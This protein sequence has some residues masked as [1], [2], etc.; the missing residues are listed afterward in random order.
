MALEISGSAIEEHNAHFCTC[1][2]TVTHVSPIIHNFTKIIF[3]FNIVF[4]FTIQNTT[5][6][7]VFAKFVRFPSSKLDPLRS[8]YFNF[9]ILHIISINASIKFKNLLT[10]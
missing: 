8:Y 9:E 10:K 4:S 6:K 2:L 3:Y 1:F 5:T 7:L